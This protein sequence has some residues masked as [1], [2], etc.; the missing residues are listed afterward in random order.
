VAPA[1]GVENALGTGF[2]IPAASACRQCHE[3][4]GTTNVD[5]PIG[6]NAI[7]LNHNLTGLN[8]P[9]LLLRDLLRN[10]NAATDITLDNAVV[11][12]TAVQRA[13]LG[14]LHG[15]CSHCHGGPSPHGHQLLWTP[16]ATTSLTDLPMFGAGETGAVCHC[17]DIWRGHSNGSI[18]YKYRINPSHGDSSGIIGRLS[19]IGGTRDAMPPVGRKGSD[20]AGIAAVQAYIDSLD[21]SACAANP[22]TCSQ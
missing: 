15:N 22:P 14:Y 18:S 1:A 3:L 5:A 17:L 2:D 6:F 4:V 19:A 12:G 11:P 8:L 7:Q 10:G 9:Q 16:V 21:G 20:A 13:G